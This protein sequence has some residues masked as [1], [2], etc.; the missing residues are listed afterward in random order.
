VREPEPAG[1]WRRLAA[2][3]VDCAVGFLAWGLAAMWL[4]IAAW[5][6]RRSPLELREVALLALLVLALGVTLHVVYHV[7][8]VGGC[9]QT[10]G[11]MALGIMVVRR[12]GERAGHGR[13]MV[14]CLGGMFSAL[15]LGLSS[16]GVLFGREHRGFAD[17]LAGTRVVRRPDGSG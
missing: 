6:S 8:F 15:T 14:R 17:W 3:L 2:G 16:I 13:A 7:A 4:T 5:T 11:K 10:P 9:G 12:D 1:L